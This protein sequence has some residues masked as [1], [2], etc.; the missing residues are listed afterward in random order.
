MCY[1]SSLWSYTTTVCMCV[2][3]CVCVCVCVCECVQGECCNIL[4]NNSWFTMTQRNAM[5]EYNYVIF[6][7]YHTQRTLQRHKCARLNT[8]VIQNGQCVQTGYGYAR[9]GVKRWDSFSEPHPFLWSRYRTDCVNT[10]MYL[11]TACIVVL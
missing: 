3:M 8:L 2:C 11:H 4:E 10:T 9:D 7:C 1:T 5:L 6:V